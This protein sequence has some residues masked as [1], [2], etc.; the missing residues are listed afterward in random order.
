MAK[1]KLPA[2]EAGWT[3]AKRPGGWILAE[4]RLPDGS[5][6]RRRIGYAE[7]RNRASV[8]IGGR[9]ATFEIA[10][11]RE[12]SSGGAADLEAALTAQFPGKVRKIL[13]MPGQSVKAGDKLLLVEAMKME[14]AVATPVAGKVRVVRVKEGQ[15]VSPG[16]KFLELDAAAEPKSGG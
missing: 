3:F 7:T 13:V 10:V 4:R 12:G 15:Q 14:F 1:V 6:E 9:L 16:E 5:V 2:P 11:G 8:S